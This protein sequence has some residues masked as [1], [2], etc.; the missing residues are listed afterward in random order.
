MRHKQNQ[1]RSVKWVLF[2]A[3]AI[4]V[5]ENIQ[6]ELPS[7]PPSRTT[8]VYI[9]SSP[10]KIKRILIVPRLGLPGS[11]LVPS[12]ADHPYG[13]YPGRGFGNINANFQQGNPPDGIAL[14]PPTPGTELTVK[15]PDMGIDA[16]RLKELAD[17]MREDDLRVSRKHP[18]TRLRPSPTTAPA[19]APLIAPDR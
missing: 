10:V 16:A 19:D 18:L 14:R 9:L 7:L 17:G 2:S 15:S 6:A 3:A 12:D 13:Y 4:V 1:L 11:P 8:A 5:T